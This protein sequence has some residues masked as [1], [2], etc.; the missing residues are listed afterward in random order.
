MLAKDKTSEGDGSLPSAGSSF[1]L[2]ENP[3]LAVQMAPEAPP[4]VWGGVNEYIY[5]LDYIDEHVAYYYYTEAGWS[6]EGLI[7]TVLSTRTFWTF[8]RE[9]S[10]IDRWSE[11][12]P[13]VDQ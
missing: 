4:P 3:K 6:S 1:S 9:F 11:I 10:S 12:L 2:S 13:M 8:V 5:G 7:L